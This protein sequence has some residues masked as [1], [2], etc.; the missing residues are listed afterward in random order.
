L[1]WL[2]GRK[3]VLY[4]LYTPCIPLVCP[5]YVPCI[6]YA[7]NWLASPNPLPNDS[8]EPQKYDARAQRRPLRG[9]QRWREFQW[10][11]YWTA[12]AALTSAAASSGAPMVMR[13]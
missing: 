3:Q 8:V 13:K 2:L 6:E 7:C 1:E 12:F 10:F 5:L 11:T 9:D 4:L